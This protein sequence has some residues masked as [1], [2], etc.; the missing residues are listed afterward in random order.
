MENENLK[1]EQAKDNIVKPD[2]M[3]SLPELADKLSKAVIEH[4]S[5]RLREDVMVRPDLNEIVG[6]AF[7]VRKCL[8]GNFANTLLAEV[9]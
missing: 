2:V 5:S 3:L 7:D 6:I 4:F 1:T 8:M 9:F